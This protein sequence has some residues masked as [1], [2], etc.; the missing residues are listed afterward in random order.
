[1]SACMDTDT[2]EHM[3]HTRGT[4]VTLQHLPLHNVCFNLPAPG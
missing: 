3:K 2:Q 4:A 1:M